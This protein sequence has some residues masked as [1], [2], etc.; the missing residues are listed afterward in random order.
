MPLL[1]FY[2]V[3][4]K[5]ITEAGHVKYV[6]QLDPEHLIFEGHF[7]QHPILPGV[8][9]LQL[10]KE[11][12]EQQLNIE[13][14]LQRATNVKFL[15]LVNPNIHSILVCNLHIDRHQ[16]MVKLKNSITFEDETVVLKYNGTY[17]INS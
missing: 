5:A 7:P 8:A 15:S 4:E 11:L 10:L 1:D 13:L 3:L 9:M 6:I 2:T 12:A 17:T 16:N 14:Q